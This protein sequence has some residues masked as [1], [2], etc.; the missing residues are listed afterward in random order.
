MLRPAILYQEILT[1]LYTTLWFQEKYKFY[2]SGWSCD[3]LE[4][5]KTTWDK[6]EFVSVDKDGNVLGFIDYWVDRCSNKATG[7]CAVSFTEKPTVTFGR[8][9]YQVIDDIFCKFNFNKLRFG[10]IIGNP[11]ET[12]Y[13]KLIAKYGGTICGY[14][15]EEIK[16]FDGK[17]Y[18]LKNYE[19]M[20]EDYMQCK[21]D[22]NKQ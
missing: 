14:M 19:I 12:T 15:K 9:L 6:H 11:I 4:L 10:V 1:K 22:M 3:N 5:K 17:L 13:D 16:L 18:D 8:D 21:K 2:L 7:L 20:R